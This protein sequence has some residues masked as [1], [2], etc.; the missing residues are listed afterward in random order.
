[1]LAQTNLNLS[2]LNEQYSA[3]LLKIRLKLP[4][5]LIERIKTLLRENLSASD[6]TKEMKNNIPDGIPSWVL[7]EYISIHMMNDIENKRGNT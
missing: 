7:E 3:E 2:I 6:I 5:Y 4:E 1:L